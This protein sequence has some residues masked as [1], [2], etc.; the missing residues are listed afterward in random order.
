M[1]ERKPNPYAA[2]SELLNRVQD[3][4]ASDAAA[5]RLKNDAE[6]KDLVQKG[7]E[8]A[9]AEA[10]ATRPAPESEQKVHIA[11]ARPQPAPGHLTVPRAYLNIGSPSLK[12][13]A[14]TAKI[15]PAEDTTAVVGPESIPKVER[16]WPYVAAAVAAMCGA[17][18]LAIFMGG[19]NG[20]DTSTSALA[21]ASSARS[22]PTN[23]PSAS[24][25]PVPQESSEPEAQPPQVPATGSAKSSTT[26]TPSKP[27]PS[28][29]P[30]L[31]PSA[32]NPSVRP[33]AA[34]S[35]TGTLPWLQ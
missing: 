23:A 19:A 32:T 1:T 16:K 13:G 27:R 22:E 10:A 3:Q 6:L 29:D 20:T 5:E 15:A 33:S 31:R 18:L 11:D 24:E 28:S 4:E 34:P 21:L 14:P 8:A 17:F 26:S 35:S 7:K 9:A 30:S 25:S 2:S 12:K